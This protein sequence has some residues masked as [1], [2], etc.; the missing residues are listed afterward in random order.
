[1][2]NKSFHSNGLQSGFR[3]FLAGLMLLIGV[4]LNQTITFSVVAGILMTLPSFNFKPSNR[5][6]VGLLD[7]DDDEETKEQKL[8]KKIER[9]VVKTIETS[10]KD[11]VTKAQMDK[12]VEQLNKE[13]AKLSEEGMAELKQRVDKLAA[14]NERLQKELSTAND[15]MVQQGAAL[16]KLN[17][18]AAGAAA[19]TPKTFRQAIKDAI[20]EHK[21]EVLKERNDD[22]GKRLS[23]KDYFK[24]GGP[25]KTPEFVIKAAVD[26]LQGNIVG[27]GVANLRL[28]EMDPQRVGIPLTI[29][30]HVMDVFSV[31]NITKPYMA[32][33]VVYDYENGAATKAEGVASQKSSF[34]FKTVLFPAFYIATH[35]TLSD[36]TLDDLEEALDEISTVA[37]DMIHDA[38]DAKV[39]GASGDDITDIA[40][41]LTPG[42]H[43]DF[44]PNVVGAAIADAYIVDL[45]ASMKLQ[46]EL[47][48]Y[49]PNVVILNPADVTLL[50][51]KKNTME[52]SQSDRRVSYD[53]LGNPTGVAGLRIITSAAMIKGQVLVLDNLQTWIGRRRDMTMEI[54]YNGTDLVEGQ[55]TVVI[56]IRLAFGVRDKAGVIHA[57]DVPSAI[58]DI[59]MT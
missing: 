2:K 30:P 10:A 34:L 24:G 22:Y 4:V 29:Y 45:I 39:L 15:T 41:I 47:N 3:L 42:K 6:A 18:N 53:S 32:L 57:S 38:I 59:T 44:D 33:L 40:G 9:L 35:F 1:M 46:A 49:K 14:D 55:K 56:K 58:D 12:L 43:T 26:M 19:T 48:K 8:L 17:D 7:D 20:M 52:D 54:G 50:A 21:D 36:E 27:T 28:T 31:K 11:T 16:K 37:P 5:L 51:A 23:M 25:R 13:V